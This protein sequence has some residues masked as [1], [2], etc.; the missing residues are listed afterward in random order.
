MHGVTSRSC[1]R[2]SLMHIYYTYRIVS[3]NHIIRSDPQSDCS[4][5]QSSADASDYSTDAES[6]AARLS[7]CLLA[8][9]YWQSNGLAIDRSRV[10]VL[11]GHNCVV[12]LGKLLTRVCLCHQAV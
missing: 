8:L 2:R 3:G 6:S 9:R 1:V 4:D 12:A 11:A 10:R 5:N 7:F